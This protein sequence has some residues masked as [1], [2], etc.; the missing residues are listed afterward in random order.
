MNALNTIDQ[1]LFRRIVTGAALPLSFFII[2]LIAYANSFSGPF[3]FDDEAGILENPRIRHLWPLTDVVSAPPKTTVAGR[4]I[5]SLSLAVNY[6]ISGYSVWSYHVLNLII[7]IFA[8]LTLYGIIRRILLS[9]RLKNRF[10]ENAAAVAWVSAVIW[11]VHPVQTE[12]V[13]YVIQRTES[14]MGLFYLLTLYVAIRAMQSQRPFGWSVLSVICCALGMGSKEVM[15]TA[16]VLVLL[17]DRAFFAG[18]FA[19]ALQRRR[20]LYASLA[21]TW[22]ILAALLW[23]CPRQEQIEGFSIAGSLNYAMNQGVVIVHY[24]RLVVWPKGLCLDYFWPVAKNWGKLAAPELAVLWMAAVTVWGLIRNRLWSYPLVWFFGTLAVTSSFVPVKDL[25]FEHRIYLPLAGL[26]TLLV[27][28]GYTAAEYSAKQF[29]IYRAYYIA[30]T[31]AAGIIIALTC[32]TVN[33]NKDYNSVLSIWQ[34]V[35]KVSPD[36]ARAYNGIGVA[37]QSQGRLDEAVSY[38]QRS[39][40]LSPDY[41]DVHNN[42]GAVLQLQGKSDQA[43]SYFRKAVSLNPDFAEAYSNLGSVLTS[44]GRF[45]EA[46][47]CYL[48]SLQIKPD[49]VMPLTMVA[50]L[51]SVH[52]DPKSRNADQAIIFAGLAAELTKYQD[53][54]VLGVLAAAYAADNQFGRAV[55]T[56][57]KALDLASAAGQDELFNRINAQLKL[58]KQ[59]KQFSL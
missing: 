49:Q 50:K 3:I 44:Q 15:V 27:M 34:S 23:S 20:W 6:A 57:Q 41:A 7:H 2:G 1:R 4:P 43:V 22:V 25:V 53:A 38:Y 30:F 16:P 39:I 58:Y 12:S 32:V 14:L 36:N 26:V 56:A 46:I 29:R 48:Q 11:L 8:G 59:G 17:Y 54:S 31:L 9:E 40:Q 47:S 24:L 42:I 10:A 33:R 55:E 52:P 5:A 18:S 35:L 21:A 45:D 19:A 51:L 28:S 13:T 37:L